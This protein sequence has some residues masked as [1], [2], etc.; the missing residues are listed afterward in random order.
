MEAAGTTRPKRPSPRL[1][2]TADPMQSCN[3]IASALIPTPLGIAPWTLGLQ[4]PKPGKGSASQHL[5]ERGC[6]CASRGLSSLL[7][8]GGTPTIFI[9]SR[10]RLSFSTGAPLPYPAV[11]IDRH[12]PTHAVKTCPTLRLSF[13]LRA[14]AA[15]RVVNGLVVPRSSE[16]VVPFAGAAG[17]AGLAGAGAGAGAAACDGAG[18]A[19]GAAG[20][21]ALPAARASTSA[22]VMRPFGPVPAIVARST[23]RKRRVGKKGRGMR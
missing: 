23:C 5:S 17:A 19:I 8:C 9:A 4:T 11:L 3:D 10:K 7:E 1:Q 21:T 16:T 22:A 2:L 12:A 6:G 20:A 15:C 14:T 18:A 13:M